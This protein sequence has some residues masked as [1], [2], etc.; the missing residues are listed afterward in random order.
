MHAVQMYPM[1]SSPDVAI[2]A[3]VCNKRSPRWIYAY[4]L[5][6]RL[7]FWSKILVVLRLITWN[8]LVDLSEEQK[9]S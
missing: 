4:I 9:V 2:I 7:F 1:A 6:K 5:S 3:V 8:T